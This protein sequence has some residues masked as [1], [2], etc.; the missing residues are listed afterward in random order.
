MLKMSERK[1]CKN[2][3][4]NGRAFYTGSEPSPKGRGYCARFETIGTKMKGTDGTT[5]IVQSRSSGSRAWTKVSAKTKILTRAKVGSKV[6]SRKERKELA[7]Y[8]R[9][10]TIRAYNPLKWNNWQSYIS[11]EQQDIYNSLVKLAPVFN[12]HGINVFY[13][14]WQKNQQ[15]GYFISDEPWD[16][17][18]AKDINYLDKP[19]II[20]AFK[21][22]FGKFVKLEN[23]CLQH[24]L[25]KKWKPIIDQIMK[26]EFKNL[27][28]WNGSARKAICI[29]V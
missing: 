17:L 6:E 1:L 8:P 5:W 21:M 4:G 28:D 10:R 22:V 7:T 11:D 23:V 25:S 9:G 24:T 15:L 27:Y 2:V 3:R 19:Y 29:A 18:G 26:K 13:C 12:Q 20:V 14:L 16:D